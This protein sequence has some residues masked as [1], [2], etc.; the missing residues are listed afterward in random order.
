M[1]RNT[2]KGAVGSKY[3]YIITFLVGF[4]V[5]TKPTVITLPVYIRPKS[6]QTILKYIQMIDKVQDRTQSNIRT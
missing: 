2:R 1:L 6:K 3:I 5:M 4:G